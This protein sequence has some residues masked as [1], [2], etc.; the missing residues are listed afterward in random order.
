MKYSI[1][2]DFF[3]VSRSDADDLILSSVQNVE[4]GSREWLW[5]VGVLDSKYTGVQVTGIAFTNKRGKV[6]KFYFLI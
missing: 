5:Q 3:P 2:P 6:E 4:V 1:F